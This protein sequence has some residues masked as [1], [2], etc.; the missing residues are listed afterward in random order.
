M[1][2]L[3]DYAQGPITTAMVGLGFDLLT[4]LFNML[5]QQNSFIGDELGPDECSNLKTLVL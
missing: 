2:I 3:D 5:P 1:L 4:I